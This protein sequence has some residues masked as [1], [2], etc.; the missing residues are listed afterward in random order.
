MDA[1]VKSDGNARDPQ[2]MLEHARAV[3]RLEA[4][5]V[6]GL[7]GLLS[8]SFVRAAE[9]VLACPGMVIVTGIGKAGLIGAKLSAT[10]AS[11]GTPS[12]SLHPAE[13]LHGDLGRVRS[14]DLLL[15]LSNSG[16]S[17][18]IKALLPAVRRLGA[19]VIAMTGQPDS[20][21]A[22]LSDCVLDIGRI[23]EACPLGLAPTASTAA[24]LAL[25]DALAMVVQSAR[26]FSRED[27]ALFHPGGALGRR[28]M[29]VSE[30][31]RKGE[32]IPL[33]TSGSTL[34]SVLARMSRTPGR[35]GAALIVDASGALQGIFTDGDLRR[36]CESASPG[37][38]DLPIDAWMGRDPKWVR[39]DQ[40][41]E[42]AAHVLREHR[43]DQ[44]PVLGA[45]RQPVG[46]LDIQDVLD[47]R[48]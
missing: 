32:Q 9:L 40:L 18:E 11:T 2:Q 19:R 13:A 30:V 7:E 24:L 28:L 26:G 12:L 16:E 14:N 6:A 17:A 46:L 21:L 3:I 34:R 23:D 45:D 43:I 22:R 44:L 47:V 36:V 31:M 8:D 4:R 38:F 39:A 42:E 25:G 27:Y 10:L 5:T 37:A 33:V 41:V 48:V 35:P 1:A 15:A 29:R 20:T